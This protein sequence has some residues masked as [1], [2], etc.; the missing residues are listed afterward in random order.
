MFQEF[1]E[2]N[3]GDDFL[4]EFRQKIAD[5]SSNNI[6]ERR[7]EM[8]RSKS[9]FIGAVSGV[10]LAGVVGWFI[11]APQYSD[12]GNVEIPVIR[13]PQT[14]V[15]VQPS[16]PGG[17]EILNQ[18]KSVYDIIEKKDAIWMVMEFIEGKTLKEILNERGRIEENLLPPPEQPKLPEV[19]P[20][21]QVV[22]AAP[23]QVNDQIPEKVIGTA[24]VAQVK[25]AAPLPV[26]ANAQTGDAPEAKVI[27][28]KEAVQ[29]ENAKAAQAA[30]IPTQPKVQPAVQ[31]EPKKPAALAK[32]TAGM[33]QI[34][35]MSSPNRQAVE[36]AWISLSKKYKMLQGQP[37]EIEAADL[38]FDKTF[39]RLK[40][41]AFIDRAGADELCKDIKA[42]GGTCI[43]KKK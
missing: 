16:E 38:D 22:Q 15:K 14:A 6:E 5:Q 9:V 11:L 42:L 8:K 41:G 3:K 19:I 7:N 21:Q 43:V 17:M 20:S 31:P 27:G 4:N 23:L 2:D 28:L 40:A 33:W 36:K 1:P 34:Q 30:Q 29:Q 13:R 10:A 35:L 12:T 24:P 39:Y 25:E 32:A 26:S 37:H 18:D